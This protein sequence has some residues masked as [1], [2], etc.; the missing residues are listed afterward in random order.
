M[1]VDG[2][3]KKNCLKYLDEHHK[4]YVTFFH[5]FVGTKVHALPRWV[6]VVQNFQACVKFARDFLQ[7]NTKQKVVVQTNH[8]SKNIMKNATYYMVVV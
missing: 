3:V 5:R 7:M 4:Q 2:W 8:L 1:D 6:H